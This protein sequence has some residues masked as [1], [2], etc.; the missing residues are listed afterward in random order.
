MDAINSLLTPDRCTRCT[1]AV[2]SSFQFLRSSHA[3]SQEVE[4][5]GLKKGETFLLLKWPTFL[6]VTFSEIFFEFF[7]NFQETP[8]W[9]QSRPLEFARSKILVN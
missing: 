9:F 2:F 3:V 4:R 8:V 1:F 5:F 6:S 7:F